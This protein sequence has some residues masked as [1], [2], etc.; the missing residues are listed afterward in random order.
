MSYLVLARKWRPQTFDDV[1]GQEHITKTLRRSIETGRIAHAYLFTGPRGVGK[2]TT[3]RILAKALNCLSYDAPTPTPC[4]KCTSCIEITEGRSPDVTEMDGA[5]HRGIDDARDLQA[6]IQYA[7]VGR[8]KVIIIDEVH[9]LTREAF[10]ALLK[11]LEEPPANVVFI[12]ATT[13]PNAVPLTIMSRCQRFDFRL[14]NPK[15][16][17]QQIIKIAEAEG[18]SITDEASDFIALRAEGSMRDALSMLDQI[19][20]A[21]PDEEITVET[22]MKF[23]GVVPTEAFQKIAEAIEEKDT[24][25]ALDELSSLL[26]G[27]I[28]PLQVGKGLV[29]HFRN[30]LIAKSNALPQDYP[31]YSLYEEIAKKHN[32]RDLLRI[33]KV[34]SDKY[35]AMRRSDTPRYILEE[36]LIYLSLLDEVVDIKALLSNATSSG[37]LPLENRK[38]KSNETRN[39][40]KLTESYKP[41]QID[42]QLANSSLSPEEK[43]IEALKQKRKPLATLLDKNTTIKFDD[44]RILIKFPKTMETVREEILVNSEMMK[45]LRDAADSV[46]EN[47]VS[48]ELLK[49]VPKKQSETNSNDATVPENVEKILSLFEAK[50]E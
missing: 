14:I 22:V 43:F 1:V 5:S 3:A 31:N 28:D 50:L 15:K 24:K 42:E 7:T 33:V 30:V 47:V 35:S 36:A 44:G 29:E 8:Y 37:E 49:D 40:E 6:N 20:A 32:L 18:F 10:N 13:E 34:L 39:I 26:E 19:F 45:L 46:L 25:S 11:T 38:T 9:M 16:I 48:V 2:T 12:F 41:Q 23:L 17:S 27:G 4:N 21:E